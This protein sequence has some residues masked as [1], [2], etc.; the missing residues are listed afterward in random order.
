MNQVC[1]LT[2]LLIFFLPGIGTQIQFTR[3]IS[4]KIF[5]IATF[6]GGVY[7][8]HSLFFR[9]EKR[10]SKQEY[11]SFNL[12]MKW[13]NNHIEFHSIEYMNFELILHLRFLFTLTH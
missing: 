12:K 6:N 7:F 4:Q 5:C 13:K 10:K 8:F 3:I 2:Q 11:I 1:A 9:N